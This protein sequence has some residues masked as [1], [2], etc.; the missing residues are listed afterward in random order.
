MEEYHVRN[1][2]EDLIEMHLSESIRK[3]GTCDCARCRADIKAFALNIF[4]PHYVVTDL[5]DALTRANALSVQFRVDVM[6]AIMKGI[7]IVK[8]SPRHDQ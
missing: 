5:G 4:P 2:S 8:A 3:S 1:V 7:V 6:T